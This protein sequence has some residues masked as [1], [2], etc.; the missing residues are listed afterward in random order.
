[1]PSRQGDT[2]SSSQWGPAPAVLG[3]VH[4]SAATSRPSAAKLCFLAAIRTVCHRWNR[5][6]CR[7]FVVWRRVGRHHRR[8]QR[9]CLRRALLRG[10][11]TRRWIAVIAQTAVASTPSRTAPILTKSTL[12]IP[13]ATTS[14]STTA[15]PRAPSATEVPSTTQVVI[16]TKTTSTTPEFPEFP[17]FLRPLGPGEAPATSGCFQTVVTIR[18]GLFL[19]D[20]LV[21]S[22]GHQG[23]QKPFPC[24]CLGRR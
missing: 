18:R 7:G 11:R 16:L 1:M 6:G 10:S 23:S 20:S 9:S 12:A 22:R 3:R 14:C 5:H 21:Q 15:A 8:G 13:T 24:P 19:S 17:E 2:S 4:E